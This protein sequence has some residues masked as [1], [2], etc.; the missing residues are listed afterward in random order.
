MRRCS[1]LSVGAIAIA[2]ILN[3]QS[4]SAAKNPM[5]SI[6]GTVMEKAGGPVEGASVTVSGPKRAHTVTDAKGRF[7]F[8]GLPPGSYVV[9]GWVTPPIHVWKRIAVA[10]GQALMGVTLP[11]E[12]S[13]TIS[14]QVMDQDGKPVA[15]AD[16]FLVGRAYEFGALRYSYRH[17]T[18]SDDRGIY[19]LD[20]LF[21]GMPYLVMA[22]RPARSLPSLS[23]VATDPEAR[24][25]AFAPTYY[26]GSPFAEGAEAIRLRSGERR[27]N[28]NV[29]ML[30][31]SN[32]CIEGVLLQADGQPSKLA[33]EIT[34]RTP[35]AGYYP[36]GGVYA[37]VPRGESGADGRFRICDLYAGGFRLV[38]KSLVNADHYGT[39]DID[40]G[41]RD[42]KNITVPAASRISLPGAV[43]ILEAEGTVAKQPNLSLSVSLEPLYRARYS[44]EAL[45]AASRESAFVFP[46]LI[47]G[48]YSVQ[49]GNLPEKAYVKDI[50]YGNSSV[51]FSPLKVGAEPLNT[52]LRVIVGTDGASIRAIVR[53]KE[54]RG[55]PDVPIAVFP[56]AASTHGE[57]AAQLTVGQTDSFGVFTSTMLG[58]AKYRILALRRATTPFGS[59]EDIRWLLANRSKGLEIAAGKGIEAQVMLEPLDE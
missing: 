3:A 18:T 23:P 42:L 33:F 39:V 12:R 40:I 29:K 52:P 54:G 31:A 45:S 34:D 35:A 8:K 14:G 51:L 26:P 37:D 55:V 21:P 50:L 53:D 7:T 58:P 10:D 57:V 27:E 13:A 56:Q 47:L 32:R 11:L 49:I 46:S 16:V 59:E 28:L 25:P 30:R 5:A 48:E 22:R 41:D 4:P 17:V 43:T 2:F 20:R 44:G 36:G 1:M 19:S 24:P 38:A 15:R 6:E 9:S